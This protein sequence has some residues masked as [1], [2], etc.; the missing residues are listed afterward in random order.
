MLNA[1]NMAKLLNK[2]ER[3]MEEEAAHEE[4]HA[5]KRSRSAEEEPVP[6]AEGGEIAM[7]QRIAHHLR[8]DFRRL[9]KMVVQVDR[10]ASIRHNDTLREML[11]HFKPLRNQI[12]QLTNG[13]NHAFNMLERIYQKNP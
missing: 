9:E 3:D 2:H 4:E 5:M 11:G 1:K 13:Q 8:T 7:E 10:N 6:P 12:Q